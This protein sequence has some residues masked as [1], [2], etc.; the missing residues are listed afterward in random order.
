MKRIFGFTDQ[1][2][3][4]T[5]MIGER[6]QKPIREEVVETLAKYGGKLVEFPY[7]NDSKYQELDKI[8]RAQWQCRICVVVV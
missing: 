5:V 8:S 2:M 6:F 4:F 3:L 7:S 1:I